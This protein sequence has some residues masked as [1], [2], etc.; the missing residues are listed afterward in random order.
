MYKEFSLVLN[1][2][3]PYIN[4]FENSIKPDIYFVLNS[5]DQDVDQDQLIL[6]DS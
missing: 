4:A 1:V 5:V 2:L 6:K 3:K